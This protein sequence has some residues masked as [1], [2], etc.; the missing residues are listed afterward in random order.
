LAELPVAI[1]VTLAAETLLRSDTLDRDVLH[2]EP[3]RSCRAGPDL[4]LAVGERTI[5]A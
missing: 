3:R 5:E 1:A 2:L 4:G